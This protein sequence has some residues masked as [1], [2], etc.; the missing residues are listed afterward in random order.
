[1]NEYSGQKICD[2]IL[3]YADLNNLKTLEIGCGTGRISSILSTK[4]NLL[5]AI[6]PDEHAIKKARANVSGVDF[7]TGSGEAL[8]FPTAFFDIVIFTLS[9]H[10]QDSQ[11]ALSEAMR[12]LR[13]DGIILVIEPI[14]D[15]EIE[16]LFSFLHNENKEKVAAQNCIDSSGLTTVKSE[17]FTSDWVFEDKTDLFN[18]LFEYY[19]MPFD[20]DTAEKISNFLGEKINSNPIVCKDKMIIQCLQV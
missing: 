8:D 11:K 9:L 2:K 18:S 6:D 4:T 20:Y 10:H 7:R 3:E 19:D 1:M 14:P 17:V 5:F 16:V 13:T 12:V 15:G